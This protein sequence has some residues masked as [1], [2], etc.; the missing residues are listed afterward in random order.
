MKIYSP[1]SL[2]L[3]SAVGSV[4]EEKPLVLG[5][6]CRSLKCLS[7]TWVEKGESWHLSELFNVQSSKTKPVVLLTKAELMVELPKMLVT[8]TADGLF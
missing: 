5:I 4:R 1:K 2:S 6:T 8:V 3:T 7:I